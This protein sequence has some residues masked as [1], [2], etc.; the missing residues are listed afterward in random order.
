MR[1]RQNQYDVAGSGRP[2]TL[3]KSVSEQ[4][5]GAGRFEGKDD[6]LEGWE[7]YK[8]RFKGVAD[9]D[10]VPSLHWCSWKQ[11]RC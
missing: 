6:L 5:L 2:E 11:S 3:E 7:G 1:S 4:L 8:G 10:P 9:R